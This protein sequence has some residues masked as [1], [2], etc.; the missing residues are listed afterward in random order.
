MN[1]VSVCD[2]FLIDFPDTKIEAW[3]QCPLL[4]QSIVCRVGLADFHTNPA[5]QKNHVSMQCLMVMLE[6]KHHS[7]ERV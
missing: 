1:N 2:F 7:R 5:V 3:L 6:E 4:W